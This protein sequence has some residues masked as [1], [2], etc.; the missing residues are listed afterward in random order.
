M[1]GTLSLFIIISIV[2]LLTLFHSFIPYI[3]NILYLYNNYYYHSNQL[4]GKL[5]TLLLDD[6]LINLLYIYVYFT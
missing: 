2:I 4:L 3:H 6:I 5:N 1:M